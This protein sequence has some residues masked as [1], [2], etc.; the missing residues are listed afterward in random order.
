MKPL[1]NGKVY[2]NDVNLKKWSKKNHTVLRNIP[3]SK[4]ASMLNRVVLQFLLPEL[5]GHAYF[6]KLAVALSDVI[7]IPK[8]LAIAITTQDLYKKSFV[9]NI[10]SKTSK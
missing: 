1:E 7:M 2:T 10:M 6:E 4:I 5:T 9:L 3:V 8:A